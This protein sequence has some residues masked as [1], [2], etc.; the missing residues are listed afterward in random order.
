GGEP[1]IRRYGVA[2]GLP[3]EK[4]FGVLEDAAGHLWLTTIAGLSRF[5]PE[6]ETF[7]NFD[8]SQG[9]S[10]SEF[11][12]GASFRSRSGRFFV[13][14][15]AGL[16][17]FVPEEFD[18]AR[19][20]P[21]PIVLTR[22]Q[23]L[24]Q[25]ADVDGPLSA[26]ESVE[27]THRE[28]SVS[29]EFAALDFTAPRRNLYSYRLDGFDADWVG[30]ST[31]RRVTYTNLDP[32]S[33]TFRVRGANN[34]GVWNEEG[35]AI[36]LTVIPPPWRTW[37]AYALYA[38]VGM[39]VVAGFVRAQRRKLILEAERSRE[40]ERLVDERTRELAERNKELD[41]AKQKFEQASLTDPLTDLRNR[42]YLSQ[43]IAQNLAPVDRFY[44]RPVDIDHADRPDLAFFIC[45]L[46]GFK[47]VNDR[48]G[49]AA[50]NRVLVEV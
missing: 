22:F 41:Q 47:D 16:N 42:R 21:P 31:V 3:S 26:L 48:Y 14:S 35:L 23:K 34:F 43:S 20:V 40:L 12:S 24:N 36:G 32:G 28:L 2:Q 19:M 18:R 7:L 39:M 10:S 46:D 44:S 50:G 38:L 9:L 37:W 33:Y 6:S 17:A 8:L 5:D 29:F 15:G 25:D 27:L 13:G 4:I 30:P 49:H 1:A 11:N 45:D